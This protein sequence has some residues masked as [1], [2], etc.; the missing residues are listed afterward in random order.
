MQMK[1]MIVKRVYFIVP[2]KIWK[3]KFYEYNFDHKLLDF[4]V[5]M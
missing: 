4:S 5:K 1:I 2:L 3:I